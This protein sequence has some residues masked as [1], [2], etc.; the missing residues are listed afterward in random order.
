MTICIKLLYSSIR[1]CLLIRS[2]S[3]R[4]FLKSV[5]S[6]HCALEDPA[7]FFLW[8]RFLFTIQFLSI[9]RSAAVS[10]CST[11][12]STDFPSPMDQILLSSVFTWLTWSSVSGTLDKQSAWGI[13]FPALCL[14]SK[15]NCPSFSIHLANNPSGSLKLYNHLMALW[16]V[17]P[18]ELLSQ[19][20]TLKCWVK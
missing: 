18:K 17:I 6:L 13:F 19:K 8:G 12:F 5:Q 1:F 3:T 10:W 20:I 16:P 4:K 14:I 2:F 9:M 11:S 15:S 7:M